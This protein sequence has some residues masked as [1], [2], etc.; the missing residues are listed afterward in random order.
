MGGESSGGGATLAAD[1]LP[2]RGQAA[3]LPAISF[4]E[5]EEISLFG[6]G[7]AAV[8]DGAGSSVEQTN[9]PMPLLEPACQA[10]E[11]WFRTFQTKVP[12]WTD[13]MGRRLNE[14]GEIGG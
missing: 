3:G 8:A 12:W 2:S 11:E 9:W 10:S 1:I 4:S 7:G 6:G 14:P 5:G 13:G